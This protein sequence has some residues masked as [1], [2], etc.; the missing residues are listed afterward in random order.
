MTTDEEL[1]ERWR[2]GETEAG[3]VLF[4]R[5]FDTVCR[6]FDNKVFGEVRDELVQTT[7]LACV[8]AR[9]QF[10][11]KSS[12]RT[13][14]FTIARNELYQHLRHKRRHL[15]RLD[16]GVTSLADLDITPRTRISGGEDRQRLLSALRTLPLEQQ[17]L[18]E[19]HYWEDMTPVQLAEVFEI[20]GPTARTRLFRARGALREAME[21]QSSGPT[22]ATES[23][24]S[25]DAWARMLRKK[26]QARTG[27][28]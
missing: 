4:Q 27:G 23:V 9:D 24:E 21:R 28:E 25:L 6:F 14:L 17:V 18:L 3:E 26:W 16:F 7:F 13:Y 20:A 8:R 19:L 1:L 22:S 10:R 15:D 2:A 11:G 12:F 5:Y